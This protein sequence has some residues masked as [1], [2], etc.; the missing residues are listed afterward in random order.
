MHFIFHFFSGSIRMHIVF[1]TG[2][3]NGRI[4]RSKNVL[5][6]IKNVLLKMNFQNEGHSDAHCLLYVLSIYRKCFLFQFLGCDIRMHIPILIAVE[7]GHIT[8]RKMVILG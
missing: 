4:R 7:K 6:L 3:Q 2:V 8:N 1:L 5:I